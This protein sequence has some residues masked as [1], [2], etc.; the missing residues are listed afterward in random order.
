MSNEINEIIWEGIYE[1]IAE[2]HPE[3]SEQEVVKHT[4]EAFNELPE[5]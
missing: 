5:L 1:Y 3:Y 4:N 2:T